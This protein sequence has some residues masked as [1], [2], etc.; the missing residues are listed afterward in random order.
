MG[1]LTRRYALDRV[2]GRGASGTVWVA[3]DL[4]L[5]RRVALKQL[6]SALAR[7]AEARARFEREAWTIAQLRSPHIV[8][9]FDSG[10]EAGIPF[11]V[12][13]LLHGESL[14]DRLSR[15]RPPDRLSWRVAARIV[16]D[17]ARGL[18][19]SHEAGIVHRDLKPANIFLAR[20]NGKELAKLLDFGIAWLALSQG[21]ASA[22]EAIVGTPQFM[23]PE[24]FD[25]GRPDGSGD[26]WS[27][28]VVAYQLF[29]G[30]L[31]FAG[32][33]L[34]ELSQRIRSS[35][36]IRPSALQ[37]SLDPRLD[38]VFERAFAVDP[39]QRIA[40][41]AEL[42]VALDQITGEAA[43]QPIARVLF[44]DDL[45]DLENLV[46]QWFRREVKTGKYELSFARDGQQGLDLLASRPDLDV[47]ITDINMPGM[48]GLAF[49]AK[50]PDIN[51]LVR[52]VMLSAYNDMT[53]IRTAMNRGAFDFLCKPIDFDDLRQTIEKCA[54]H[55]RS[56]RQLF[57][58]HEENE[59]LRALVGRSAAERLV[60]EVRAADGVLPHRFEGS[61]AFIRVTDPL[62]G[63][64]VDAPRYLF[65]R[66]NSHFELFVPE[67]HG[68]RGAVHRFADDSLM[69]VFE[70]QDH[71]CRAVDACFGILE[72]V[73]VA[74]TAGGADAACYGVAFGLS[75]GQLVTGGVGSPALGRFERSV[76]GEAV[77]RAALLKELARPHELLASADLETTLALRY[78]CSLDVESRVNATES[79]PVCRV[80]GKVESHSEARGLPTTEAAIVL[81]QDERFAAECGTRDRSLIPR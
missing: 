52:I 54:A 77:A 59:I 60:A 56:I 41:A 65:A 19:I 24:H 36:F 58:F 13:E 62:L 78:R 50:V 15:Y 29:T 40:T 21:H 76:L 6:D 16:A 72:R 51:P 8:Q 37:K 73:R 48:D 33:T 32:N 57:D 43:Q 68:R 23:S 30:E 18:T 80:I 17:V 26:V 14:E 35:S 11:I 2:I 9:V 71:L 44:V 69:A 28:A 25:G 61:V 63:S 3:D 1:T 66:L 22:P 7:D 47:V 5:G 46:R 49:L 31:P 34:Q 53:N 55:S 4:Q 67:V 64:D 74:N 81:S 70:G 10:V 12:M 45:E 20:E 79:I 38:D 42:A 39:S 27:L 75:S